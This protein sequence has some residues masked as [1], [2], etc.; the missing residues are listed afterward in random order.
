M[1][2]MG[3]TTIMVSSVTSNCQ[4]LKIE[5]SHFKISFLPKI[6]F[7][8]SQFSQNS[9]YVNPNFHKIH[10][11]HLSEVS[12]FTKFTRWPMLTTLRRSKLEERHRPTSNWTIPFSEILV[13]LTHSFNKTKLAILSSYLRTTCLL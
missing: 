9:L 10:L 6:T 5:N 1:V 7:S 8:K 2:G 11:I 4:K 12:F 13:L 3:S